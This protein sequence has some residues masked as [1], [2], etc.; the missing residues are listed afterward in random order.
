M[1]K[2]FQELKTKTAPKFKLHAQKEYYD[3]LQS[4]INSVR[5]STMSALCYREAVVTAI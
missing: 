1:S 4:I 3:D 2:L 5:Q